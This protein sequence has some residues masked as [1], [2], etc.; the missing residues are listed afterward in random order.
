MTKKLYPQIKKQAIKNCPSCGVSIH[1]KYTFESVLTGDFVNYHDGDYEAIR[2]TPTRAYS[3]EADLL[4]PAGQVVFTCLVAA[5]PAGVAALYLQWGWYPVSA[6][7]SVVA[8]LAWSSVLSDVRARSVITETFSYQGDAR[9][10]TVHEFEQRNR[11]IRMD[12]V[13]TTSN[14]ASRMQLLEL[15]ERVTEQQFREY[16]RDIVAGKSLARKNW[17]GEGKQFSRDVYDKIVECLV[18]AG[19]VHV[20]EN[21][22]RRITNAGRHCINGMIKRG[23]I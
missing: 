15:P 18:T 2:E 20:L 14:I 19:M 6:I 8:S 5:F 1:Q 11:G 23:E 16:L 21:R 17:T 13:H 22:E 4:V 7:V 10:K 3:L 9:E 12:V